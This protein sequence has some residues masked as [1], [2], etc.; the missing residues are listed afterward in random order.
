MKKLSLSAANRSSLESGDIVFIAEWYPVCRMI[1]ATCRSWESHVGIVFREPD[2]RLV[3]AESRVPFASVTPLEKFLA[4]TTAGRFAICR[5]TGGLTDEGVAR[6]RAAV[7][8]RLGKIYHQGFNFDSPREFCS[9]FV[10]GCYREA[11]GVEI[12]RLETFQELFAHNPT[13][14]ELGWRLWFLGFIPWRRRTVTPNSQLRSP[15]LRTVLVT[16]D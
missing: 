14:P 7:A 10:Y 13:A 9:K 5:L 6:L 11:L 1:A 4:R 8:K 3:V 15:L 12:G 2:G 16:A